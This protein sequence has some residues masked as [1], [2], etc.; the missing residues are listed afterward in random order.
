[1]LARI[2]KNI[3]LSLLN[4]GESPNVGLKIKSKDTLCQET[5]KRY[6]IGGLVISF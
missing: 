4:Q 3:V 2:D 5:R 6:C 1:M